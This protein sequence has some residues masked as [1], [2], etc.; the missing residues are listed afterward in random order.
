MRLGRLAI[1]AH[2]L[3]LGGCGDTGSSGSGGGGGESK[4]RAVKISK[5]D[6]PAGEWPLTVPSGTI[7][8]DGSGGIG[9]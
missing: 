1:G 8:C 3:A 2:V 7:S 9:R 5:S 6:V 4:A